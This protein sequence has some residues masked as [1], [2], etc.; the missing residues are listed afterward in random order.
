[1]TLVVH[2]IFPQCYLFTDSMR[3]RALLEMITRDKSVLDS[4]SLAELKKV[5]RAIA[6]LENF[7]EAESTLASTSESKIATL[8]DIGFPRQRC[9][10][11]IQDNSRYKN[12]SL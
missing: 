5:S 7:T 1:M 10:E 12:I 4:F 3:A 9:I 6:L 8:M 2:V 11:A